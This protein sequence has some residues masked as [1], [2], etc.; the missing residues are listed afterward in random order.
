MEYKRIEIGD[1]IGFSTVIDEKFKKN[2][3][4]NPT[5]EEI[6]RMVFLRDPGAAT[7]FFDDAW[8]VV[9]AH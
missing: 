3:V 2:R 8:S 1:G 9:K 4:I 6:D 7:K 5:R